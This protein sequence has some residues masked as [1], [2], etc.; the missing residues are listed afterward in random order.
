VVLDR[1][2]GAA[3]QGLRDDRPTVT[4][5]V[6]GEEQDPFLLTRPILFTDAGIQ[7]VVPT[8]PALL[9]QP[10][11]HAFSDQRPPVSPVLAHKLDELP[12][13]Q[14]APRLLLKGAFPSTVVRLMSL[15]GAV[16]EALVGSPVSAIAVGWCSCYMF[17]HLKF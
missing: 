9:A 3:G 15:I 8:F 5:N 1:V 12:V 4:E 11:R 10:S 14:L 7:V 16:M 17:P 6:V 2:V 13:L